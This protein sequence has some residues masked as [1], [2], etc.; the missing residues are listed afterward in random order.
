MITN[1]TIARVDEINRQINELE[2]ELKII[3]RCGT[4]FS[5]PKYAEV[6]KKCINAGISGCTIKSDF[7]TLVRRVVAF[8]DLF[9][10][11]LLEEEVTAIYEL[12][13]QLAD[14]ILQSNA[15]LIGKGDKNGN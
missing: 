11:K 5:G 8:N 10:R 6:S 4:A 2:K 7:V 14:V 12:V 3:K 15:F 1:A 13:E 9:E